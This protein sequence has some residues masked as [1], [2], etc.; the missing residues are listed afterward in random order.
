[1]TEPQDHQQKQV[2]PKVTEVEGGNRVEFSDI[3][4]LDSRG[5]AI[6]VDGVPTAL[7][8][9][10]QKESLDDF[11]LLDD[12]YALEVNGNLS[13]LPAILRRFVGDDYQTV[14]NSLRNDTGRVT[15]KV[16]SQ[17]VRDLIGAL[18]P[19]S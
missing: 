10:V 13:K 4:A 1:V 7:A 14:L 2:K 17:F 16:A 11:E 19:K 18:N 3:T 9:T 8:V 5:K 15:I 6:K 12:M